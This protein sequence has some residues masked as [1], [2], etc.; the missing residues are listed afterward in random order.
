MS[1][2]NG[3]HL[4]TISS[5]WLLRLDHQTLMRAKA[6]HFVIPRW[7]WWRRL[8]VSSCRS[9]GMTIRA[10][11]RSRSS[12]RQLKNEIPRGTSLQPEWLSAPPSQRR[13]STVCVIHGHG[14]EAHRALC[15]IVLDLRKH[16]SNACRRGVCSNDCFALGRVV[17]EDFALGRVVSGGGGG[18][19][20]E[21]SRSWVFLKA[22]ACA[23]S[24]IHD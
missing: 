1:G 8:S 21:V 17:S 10:S 7:P 15:S 6:R 18:G 20:G 12:A 11:C 4:F 5:L 22:V 23:S 3:W 2:R 9:L 16:H 19:V 24:Q 14:D 13:R